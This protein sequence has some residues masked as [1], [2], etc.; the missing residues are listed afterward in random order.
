VLCAHARVLL[1]PAGMR[2]L[3]LA[4]ALQVRST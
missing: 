2:L 1:R 4:M 3:V